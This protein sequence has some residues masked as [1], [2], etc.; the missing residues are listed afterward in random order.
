[1]F[2]NPDPVIAPQPVDEDLTAKRKSTEKKPKVVL[3]TV[4][5]EDNPNIFVLRI[6]RQSKKGDKVQNNLNLE[7]KTPRPWR[8][9]KKPALEQVKEVDSETEKDKSEDRKEDDKKGEEDEKR[10]KSDPDPKK[11]YDDPESKSKDV[12]SE[13]KSKSATEVKLSG[14]LRRTMKSVCPTCA[15]KRL[16]CNQLF[17]TSNRLN[18]S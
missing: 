12:D 4:N 7:F 6:K 8:K 16:K 17:T 5:P 13:S 18:N 2:P 1:M 11:N 9:Q 3:P 10:K 14:G 15:T